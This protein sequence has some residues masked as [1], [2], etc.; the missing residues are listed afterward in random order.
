MHGT[1]EWLPGQPLGNDRESWSDEL[2]GDLPNVYVYAANN[3]S[4]SILAKR[5]G[6][7]TIVS[8]N[9]PPY[10][11]AGLYLELANLKDL[12]EEYRQEIMIGKGEESSD[13]DL[14]GAIW[15]SVQK[16][17]M[18]NDVPLYLDPS[19]K[20]G[21]VESNLPETLPASIFNDWVSGLSD[22]LVEL[23]S[24]LFSSGLHVLGDAPT[25]EELLAYVEAYFGDKLEGHNPFEIISNWHK[26][27]NDSL[28][29][30]PLSNVVDFLVDGVFDSASKE[31]EIIN[32]AYE[33]L[34]LLNSTTE[35]MDSVITGLDGGYISPA[36]GGDLLRYVFFSLR[37]RARHI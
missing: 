9:V 21:M 30:N 23:Q 25:D 16:S 17:G 22:Y 8:Y 6:Y 35:E 5:R 12:I 32:D 10:G 19:N 18:M 3:P 33:I 28:V 15:S 37:Y 24:R 27:K 29:G 13:D 14:K 36:P 34:D 20:D 4:E 11:R 1:E 26:Q 31:S 2:I 7:G